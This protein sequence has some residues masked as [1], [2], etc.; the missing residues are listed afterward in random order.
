MP[1]SRPLFAL[2]QTSDRGAEVFRQARNLETERAQRS[3]FG[4]R[5][6]RSAAELRR[7]GESSGD[8]R[9]RSFHG[10]QE[11]FPT[12]NMTRFLIQ[13]SLCCVATSMVVSKRSRI[14]AAFGEP[15][16]SKNVPEEIEFVTTTC[17]PKSDG[18]TSDC[19]LPRNADFQFDRWL[20][21]PPEHLIPIRSD[22]SAGKW[23]GL[24]KR[25]AGRSRANIIA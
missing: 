18:E 19:G 11:T 15:L 6:P 5:A 2:S 10:K 3:G 21:A 23:R 8:E 24:A 22:C 17:S 16:P 13:S 1:Y 9:A 7:S 25:T 14:S 12:R 20:R 4:R